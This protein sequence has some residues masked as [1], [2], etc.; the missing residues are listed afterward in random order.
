MPQRPR[1]LTPDASPRHLFGALLREWRQL[2]NFSQA[3]LAGLVY[4]S[5]D[6][7]AKV[8][9]AFRWPPAGF[10]A[11]C[12]VVLNT[13]GVLEELLPL[14]DRERLSLQVAAT[15]DAGIAAIEAGQERPELSAHTRKSHVLVGAVPLGPA[16]KASPRES[17]SRA[18]A[19]ASQRSSW[20]GPS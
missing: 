16:D 3:H 2:R 19:L 14:V 4:V 20:R 18:A 6:L 1:T 17:A 7:I 11:R 9:K 15:A 5:A 8:E 12:D 13:G 10:A